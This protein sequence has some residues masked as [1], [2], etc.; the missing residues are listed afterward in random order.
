MS[1]YMRV[2]YQLRIGGSRERELT[3]YS[4]MQGDI[5]SR[6]TVFNAVS[7]VLRDRTLPGVLWEE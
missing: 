4:I 3:L 5:T 7:I 1:E 2:P 6:L